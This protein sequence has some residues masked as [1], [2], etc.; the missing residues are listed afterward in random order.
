MFNQ[1]FSHKNQSGMVLITGLI[2][3]LLMTILGMTSVQTTTLDERMASNLNDRNRAFQAAEIAL[4]QAENQIMTIAS[5]F[6][7]STTT[8]APDPNDDDG[9]TDEIAVDEDN[10]NDMIDPVTV[11]D[12]VA[13]PVYVIQCFNAD[14]PACGISRYR[15]TARGQGAIAT[16]VV[17]LETIVA[18]PID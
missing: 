10:E 16:S 9:W 14:D 6:N 3:L 7:L 4:R 1:A 13:Q 18:R 15:V 12:V 8:V 11:P 17:V 2:F 5:P